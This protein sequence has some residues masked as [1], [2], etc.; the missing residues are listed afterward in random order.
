MNNNNRDSSHKIY[1]QYFLREVHID[2]QM[3]YEIANFCICRELSPNTYNN[4]VKPYA[5]MLKDD[6]GR[7]IINYKE[8]DGHDDH[9]PGNGKIYRWKEENNLFHIV[10]DDKKLKIC[11][12]DLDWT[13]EGGDLILQPRNDYKRN[14][15]KYYIKKDCFPSYKQLLFLPRINGRVLLKLHDRLQV[16]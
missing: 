10:Q 4:I 14:M 6:D 1:V 3:V 16:C 2:V 7:S 12:Q 15:G 5:Y 8:M 13:I 9:V 11:L